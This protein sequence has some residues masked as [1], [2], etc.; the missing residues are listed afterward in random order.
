MKE[1]PTSQTNLSTINAPYL[2]TFFLEDH[3]KGVDLD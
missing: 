3:P 1:N 2:L